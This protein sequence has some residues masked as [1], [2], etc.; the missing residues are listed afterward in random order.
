MGKCPDD[1]DIHGELPIM[2]GWECGE[3]LMIS[4]LMGNFTEQCE[5]TVGGPLTKDTVPLPLRDWMPKDKVRGTATSVVTLSASAATLIRI[6]STET[7]MTGSTPVSAETTAPTMDSAVTVL[8]D[9]ASSSSSRA[10]NSSAPTIGTDSTL[11]LNVAAIIGIAVGG[12]ILLV[13]IVGLIAFFLRHRKRRELPRAES[14]PV[15]EPTDRKNGHE[16]PE[17]DGQALGY[18]CS[19][20]DASVHGSAPVVYVELDD[21]GHVSLVGELAGHRGPPRSCGK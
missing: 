18:Q 12:T 17:L 11:P 15:Y 6:I 4:D 2:N 14:P 1:G 8:D 10:T 19:K 20:V 13:L 16:K 5:G 3:G 21:M 7:T 9:K